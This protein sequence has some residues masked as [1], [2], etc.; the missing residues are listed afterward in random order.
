MQDWQQRVINEQIILQEKITSLD[1]WLER[2]MPR[3]DIDTIEIYLLI[4]QAKAMREYNVR[5]QQRI[6]R[7]GLSW[8]P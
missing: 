2:N 1:E 4:E 6:R 8:K 7:W 5:L 3:K